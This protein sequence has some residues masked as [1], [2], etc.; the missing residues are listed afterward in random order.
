LNG[1]GQADFLNDNTL[2][3]NARSECV[4]EASQDAERTRAWKW[5][6]ES[7]SEGERRKTSTGR[8]KQ[9]ANP[10]TRCASVSTEVPVDR[11]RREMQVDLSAGV[12]RLRMRA[13]VCPNG[14]ANAGT[15]VVGFE[16]VHRKM[17][18]PEA[19]HRAATAVE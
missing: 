12:A 7:G 9:S 16:Q 13:E 15:A 3:M 11:E 8:E 14:Q 4:Q 17:C 18:R 6:A 1:D 10:T 19:D 5:I 2:N